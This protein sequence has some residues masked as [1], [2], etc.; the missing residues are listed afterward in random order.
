MGNVI[1]FTSREIFGLNAT[2]GKE[3]KE[4]ER[5]KFVP[6]KSLFRGKGLYNFVRKF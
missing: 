3:N 6:N 2:L 5:K 4:K 1:Q